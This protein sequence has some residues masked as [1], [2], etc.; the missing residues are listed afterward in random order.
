MITLNFTSP[1]QRE[2]NQ[3]Q[4]NYRLVQS[5]V[6]LSIVV[7]LIIVASLFVSQIIIQNKLDTITSDTLTLKEQKEN[8]KSLNLGQTV[9]NFN[10]LLQ[11]VSAIQSEYA[12][13]SNILIETAQNMPGDVVLSSFTI[14]KSNST[15]QFSGDAITRDSL[16]VFKNNLEE[17]PYFGNIESPISNLLSKEDISFTLSGQVI[18]NPVIDTNSL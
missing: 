13:W 18:L 2:A 7:L 11:N 1:A 14:Q 9:Q 17:S 3:F 5:L 16:L 15:F 4:K 8:E 6:I 12:A 10:S